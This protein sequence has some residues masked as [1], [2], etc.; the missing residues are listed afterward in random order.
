MQRTL[1]NWLSNNLVPEQYNLYIEAIKVIHDFGL[2]SVIPVLN[3]DRYIDNRPS[4]A[5]VDD[6]RGDIA[7][8]LGTILSECGILIQTNTEVGIDVLLKL[9]NTIQLV[10]QNDDSA[11]ILS[12]LDSEEDPIEVFSNLAAF[13]NTCD[14]TVVYNAVEDIQP[15][16]LLRLEQVFTVPATDTE[17]DEVSQGNANFIKRANAYFDA[18][19]EGVVWNFITSNSTLLVGYNVDEMLDKV[20]DG[21]DDIK[22]NNQLAWEIVGF[23]KASNTLDENVLS[24]A[25]RVTEALLEDPL[26]VMNVVSIERAYV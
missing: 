3:E 18:K 8:Y 23:I 16:L 10:E 14:W 25:S 21:L 2:E 9:V 7:S 13:V 24:E 19:K 11:S 20:A 22:D 1:S 5:I 17:D 26:R 4:V 6:I 15:E 12:I